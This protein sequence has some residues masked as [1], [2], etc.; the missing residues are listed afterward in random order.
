MNTENNAKEGPHFGDSI[1][2]IDIRKTSISTKKAYRNLPIRFFNESLSKLKILTSSTS[3]R[4]S[5]SDDSL[6]SISLHNSLESS[7]IIKIFE[8][9]L[10]K[11]TICQ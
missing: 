7:N 9:K 11:Q 5:Y 6:L 3:S 8:G 2:K 10:H 4:S 1:S